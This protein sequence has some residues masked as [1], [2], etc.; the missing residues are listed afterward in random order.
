MILD[1]L[2]TTTYYTIPD[3]RCI[4]HHRLSAL[5]IETIHYRN[6][7]RSS[8]SSKAEPAVSL[9]FPILASPPPV[10]LNPSNS[11]LSSAGNRL[12]LAIDSISPPLPGSLPFDHNRRDISQPL[13]LFAFHASKMRKW[14]IRYVPIR[15]TIHNVPPTFHTV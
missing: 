4:F 6:C 7:P 2:S 12:L 3:N 11:P 9:Y 13:A 1:I 15:Q 14:A 8:A 10:R 5:G